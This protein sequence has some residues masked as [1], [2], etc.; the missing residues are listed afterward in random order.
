MKHV[1]FE[2][3]VL[4]EA[5]IIQKK[6]CD[7]HLPPP[8]ILSWKYKI[9]QK[10]KKIR[11]IGEGKANSFTRNAINVLA[12]QVGSVSPGALSYNTFGDGV[13]NGK[14]TVGLTNTTYLTRYNV[15]SLDAEVLIGTNNSPE[16][17]DNYNIPS[18]SALQYGTN[19]VASVFDPTNRKLITVLNRIFVAK[20][21]AV[22]IVEAG[23]TMSPISGIIMLMVRDVLSQPIDLAIGESITWSYVT[24]VLYPNP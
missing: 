5:R 4:E 23:I 6:C 15:P 12:F 2:I 10:N 13:V 9:L 16:S 7:M 20:T 19:S 11:E 22:S 3:D 24:E 14:S 17:L 8:P 21:A 1:K 18:V